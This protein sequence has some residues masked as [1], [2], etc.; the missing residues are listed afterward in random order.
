MA[1]QSKELLIETTDL[2][3]I[4]KF[5]KR[6]DDW[7]RQLAKRIEARSLT[8]ALSSRDR[9]EEPILQFDASTGQW[10]TGRYVGEIRYGGGTL[11]ITPRFG[12]PAL[13]RWLSRISGVRFVA[14]KGAYES[15]HLWLWSLLA[16]LWQ[17]RL[18]YG[19]RHG[20][21]TCRIDQVHR[22]R[23]VRG[24]LDVRRTAREL[25]SGRANVVS[26]SRERDIDR[27]I[28]TPILYAFDQL[29]TEVGQLGDQRKWLT[30]RA[31]DIVE[32]MQAYY[33]RRV[34]STE[35]HESRIRYT[36][37]TQSYQGAVELSIGIANKRAMSSSAN[38]ESDVIG[39]LI[40]MAE[41]WELYLFHLLR[42][43]LD[44]Y[45]VSHV[46]RDAENQSHLLQS[47]IDGRQLGGL[48]PDILV[49]RDG[50][51]V[52]EAILDA[53]YKS[54]KPNRTRP[55]GVHREDLYQMIAYMNAFGA[56][57][58]EF[59]SALIYP[60]PGTPAVVSDLQQANPWL[61]T[62]TGQGVNFL[63]VDCLAQECDSIGLTSGE[64]AFVERVRLMLT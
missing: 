39:T 11:R 63:G 3:P 36:P 56:S 60:D 18:L 50:H 13:N 15:S 14:S 43:N 47:V 34:R 58:N 28:A 45:E 16:H 22:A 7:L 4:D 48:K 2:T 33:S 42:T 62:R 53:K 57:G 38:G 26:V 31:Q 49:R 40:D 59:S 12:V 5:T 64:R 27:R 37:I 6:E 30:P 10:W 54:T 61:T 46:G 21:P 8:L 44:G 20:I 55:T 51:S 35:I 1:K 24:R 25:R 52:V 23:S 19:A 17:T 9:D 32:Q 41:I 29:R